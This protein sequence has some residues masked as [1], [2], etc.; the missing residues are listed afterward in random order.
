M[1][2][3]I[4]Q[5]MS[6]NELRERQKRD[7]EM[8]KTCR[9]ILNLIFYITPW[10]R[11]IGWRGKGVDDVSEMVGALSRLFRIGLSKGND[12]IPCSRGGTYIQLSANSTD[13]V[14]EP[15]SM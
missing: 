11:S 3:Q 5:L 1:L 13:A 14:S 6:L 9:S 12:F 7:A 10:I 2:A 8:Q 15:T 4:R